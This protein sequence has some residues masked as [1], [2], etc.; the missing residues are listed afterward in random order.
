MTVAGLS[1]GNLTFTFCQAGD[2]RVAGDRDEDGIDTVGMFRA[3]Q[4]LLRNS[5]SAGSPDINF[6]FGT[7]GDVP[8]AADWEGDGVDA[9]GVYRPSMLLFSLVKRKSGGSLADMS[10]RFGQTGDLPVARDWNGEGFDTIGVYRPAAITLFLSNDL[11]GT[12][13][14]TASFGLV[15]TRRL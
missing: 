12:V 11:V 4:F 13:N 2:L 3:G 1:A 9:V 15:G 5:N 6:N 7:S 10:L 14:I 8:L